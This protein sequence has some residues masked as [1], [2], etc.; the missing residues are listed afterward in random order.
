MS[1]VPASGAEAGHCVKTHPPHQLVATE[2]EHQPAQ[3]LAAPVGWQVSSSAAAD[4]KVNIEG[5]DKHI[6]GCLGKQSC[7]LYNTRHICILLISWQERSAGSIGY[8]TIDR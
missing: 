5:G 2:R 4:T 8:V 3:L 1:T 6:W 7:F